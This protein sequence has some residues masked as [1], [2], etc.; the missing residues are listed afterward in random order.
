MF[1]I[2]FFSGFLTALLLL[3]YATRNADGAF[4][5]NLNI[6]P[7]QEAILKLK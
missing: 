1:Y 7:V 6:Y 4:E 2:G 3:L 5:T